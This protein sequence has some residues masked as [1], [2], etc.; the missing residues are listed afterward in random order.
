MDE[1]EIYMA[2]VEE[3]GFS[4]AAARL[5]STTASVSRRIK[6]LEQRLGTRLLQRTTRNLQLTEA[7]ELYYQAVRRAVGDLR[8]AEDQLQEVTTQPFGELRIAAPMSF[9]QRRLSSLVAR[10][11][12][13]HPRLRVSL[14]LDDKETDL[15]EAG[16]DLA[17]RIAYP[18]DSS[19]IAKPIVPIPRYL[20]AS[21]DYLEIRGMPSKPA[22]LLQHDCLHYNVI[23]ELE[24]WTFDG[25][26][27]SETVAVKGG[28]CSNNGDVLLQAAI[29]GLGITLLPDFIVA[30][31]LAKGRLVRIL[32]KRER[33]PLTLFALYPSRQFVPVKT[34][35]FID[36]IIGAIR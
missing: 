8:A 23:S 33:A 9:G 3:R 30:D 7:G 20:C 16:V 6:A 18:A 14:L 22:D 31:A 4:A 19:F 27:G 13:A 24:E 34:R 15:L 29:E 5:D 2:V 17:L 35:L 12:A 1:L 28:F 21:P 36:Y 10:F 11:A 26:A 25:P 32:K